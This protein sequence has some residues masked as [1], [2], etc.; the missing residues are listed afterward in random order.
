MSAGAPVA[1][2]HTAEESAERELRESLGPILEQDGRIVVGPW[3]SELGFEVLYW[4]PFLRWLAEAYELEPSRLVAV[5]RGG[6]GHLYAD[7]CASYVEIFDH[8]EVD[9]FR[10]LVEQRWA[11]EGGQKQTRLGPWDEAVLTAA[12]AELGW[13]GEPV[14]H[15]SLMYRLFRSYWRDAMTLEHVRRHTRHERFA[16]PADAVPAQ[17]L[18]DDY[19]AARFYFSNAFPASEA[20]REIVRSTLE[21][22]AS[23]RDVVLL[24]TGLEIDDH[25]ELDAVAGERVHRPLLDADPATNLRA[26]SALIASASAF[27]GT[28]GGFAYLAPGYGVPTFAFTAGETYLPSH[29]D[30]ARDVARRLGSSFTLVDVLAFDFLAGLAPAPAEAR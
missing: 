18:P 14:V 4:I 12:G 1:S 5:S 20:N 2:P 22:I 3:M 10:R 11:D 17:E 7:V 6:V 9:E 15:P 30:L 26:Q 19:V 16:P 28:Y 13:S 8:M 24:H 29:F 27:V 21:S 23:E 25:R